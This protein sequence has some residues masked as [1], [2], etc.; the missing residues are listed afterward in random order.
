MTLSQRITLMIKGRTNATL[1]RIE[2]PEQTLEQIVLEMGGQLDA[3]KRAVAQAT[4]NERRLRARRDRYRTQAERF[5]TSA[6]SAVERA[7]D[8][9]AREALRRCAE[10][11]R[12]AAEVEE[13][14][15]T[16]ERD[17]A[18]IRTSVERL[19]RRLGTANARLQLL[20][21]RVRQTEARVAI[22]RVLQRVDGADLYGEFERLGERVELR[23]EEEAA[24]LEIDEQI[25]GADLRHRLDEAEIDEIVDVEFEELRRELAAGSADDETAIVHDDGAA[26]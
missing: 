15:T 8:V 26:S 13:Q 24:Y 10:S 2:N 1:D 9:L 25:S 23:A 17:T 5:H 11:R 3:A 12:L 16:Q 18:R 21:A 22:G 4:A 14:L 20:R 6:R 7:D 19:Q